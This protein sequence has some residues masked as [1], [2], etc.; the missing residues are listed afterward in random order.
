MVLLPVDEAMEER[1]LLD[2][3]GVVGVDKVPVV[4]AVVLVGAHADE[5]AGD[6]WVG[7]PVVLHVLARAEAEVGLLEDGVDQVLGF[8]ADTIAPVVR[9]AGGE[10]EFF[11]GVLRGEGLDAAKGGDA[12]VCG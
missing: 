7:R 1:V 9:T 11:F 4:V 10:G 5:R 12:G 2:L 6:A 8:G 3:G